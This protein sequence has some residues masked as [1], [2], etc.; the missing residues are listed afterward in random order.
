MLPAAGHADGRLEKTMHTSDGVPGERRA[1]IERRAYDLVVCGGGLSGF[2]AAVAAAREGLRVALVQDRP[3]LGGCSSSEIRIDIHGAG[4]YWP[5]AC[6]SGVIAEVLDEERYRNPEDVFEGHLNSVWDLVLYEW[7]VREPTLD[8]LLNTSAR[9]V[10]LAAPGRIAAVRAS[11]SG[12]E[13]EFEL[14]APYFIDATGDGTVAALAGATFRYGREARAEHG[15]SF[16][17]AQADQM[18]MG[19]TIQFRTR[20]LGRPV[21]FHAPD[22]AVSY[23][24]PESIYWRDHKDAR[25]GYWWLELAPPF[26]SIRD[27]ERIR[28]ELLRHVLGVFDHIKNC[29][30]CPNCPPDNAA[31][32]AL[33]W[34][35]AVPG[36][37]ESRRVIG[38]VILTENHLRERT[39]FPDTVAYGGWFFDLH[40]PGGVLAMTERPERSA[41]DA[42]IKDLAMVGPY[43]IPL[44]SL[45]SRDVRNLFL[46]GRCLSATHVAMGSARVMGTCAVMGQAV[47]AAATVAVRAGRTPD[48]LGADGVRAVQQLLLR[49]DCYVPFVKNEDAADLARTAQASATSS[50]ALELPAGDAWV[51][52]DR[53]AMQVLPLHGGRLEAVELHLENRT[54]HP[55]SVRLDLARRTD[56]WDLSEPQAS[57][58]AEATVAPGAARWIRFDLQ[59][60]IAPGIWA[61][62]VHAAP[63]VFWSQ[64]RNPPPATAVATLQKSGRWRFEG[65][66][67]RWVARGVRL[68]PASRPYEPAN[69]ISGVARPECAANLW[70]SDPAAALPQSL[71]LELAHAAEVAEVRLAF[72]N[73]LGRITRSTPPL[74][75]APEL[76]R[77]YRIELRTD[78]AWIPVATVTQNRHRFRVHRFA[79]RRADAVRLTVTAAACGQ[80]RVYEIRIYGAQTT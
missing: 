48:E 17:P 47:A 20:D 18:V 77:D 21:P 39:R 7:A 73:N 69:V 71:Q 8:L 36:K 35:G 43:P 27:N 12:S 33:D 19:S 11:Q 3:V 9:A 60:A 15:E 66:R 34:V 25:G 32:L 26:H 40:V 2:C 44:G 74:H 28:H 58:T 5:W 56:M 68:L 16:A 49:Q 13:R 45:R 79:P 78:G 63:G 24:R 61:L 70:I 10:T 53:R 31:N 1:E 4:T 64:R 14:A 42:D 51:E 46:A 50:A 72:D 54:A 23:P 22:W 76:A 55:A 65:Q 30:G 38:D 29:N 80:A 75:V 6:E 59:A 37:R 52:L 41:Y 57:A 62:A 67:G